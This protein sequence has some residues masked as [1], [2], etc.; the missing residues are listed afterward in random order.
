MMAVMRRLQVVL[1]DDAT[2]R[3][4]AALAAL[5]GQLSRGNWNHLSA[6]FNRLDQEAARV[7]RPMAALLAALADAFRK[8]AA[9]VPDEDEIV[10]EPAAPPGPPPPR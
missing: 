10:L 6:S 1:P 3:Q 5:A 9:S 7:P 8:A 2:Y 4:L